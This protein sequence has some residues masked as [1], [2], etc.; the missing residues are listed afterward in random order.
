MADNYFGPLLMRR[1]LLSLPLLGLCASLGCSG[2]YKEEK[3]TWGPGPWK[4]ALRED[5][6]RLKTEDQRAKPILG[7]A[8]KR[9][10]DPLVDQLVRL[11]NYMSGNTPF[12][13]A[14]GMLDPYYPDRRRQAIM[15]FSKRSYGRQDPYVNY[16]AEMARADDD[17]TVRAMA[18]RALNRSRSSNNTALYIKALDDGNELVRLEAAKALANIPE[19]PA[20][21]AL[22]KRLENPEEQVDVRVACA[23][24]LRCY[25]TSQAAQALIRVLRD[26]EFAVAWQARKSLKLMTGQDHRYNQAAWLTFLTGSEKPFG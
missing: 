21:A 22:I 17:H 24:A 4:Q 2:T 9:A 14:K 3:E 25:R 1:F 8:F 12:D 16:Y 13:A 7:S 20:L 6:Q 23:D 5:Q 10:T 11:Y 15:Y 19:P 26:R 18:I